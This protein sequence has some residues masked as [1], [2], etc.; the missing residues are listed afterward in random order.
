M[1]LYALAILAG[2]VT[3]GMIAWMNWTD[4]RRGRREK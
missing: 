4:S 3:P 2:A 1:T